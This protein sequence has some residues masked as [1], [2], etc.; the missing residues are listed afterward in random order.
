MRVSGIE[1]SLM[2]AFLELICLTPLFII[3]G[4]IVPPFPVKIHFIAFGFIF[5][6][7]LMLLALHPTKK[8]VLYLTLAIGLLQLC[9]PYPSIKNTIDI[10]F[11]PLV[12]FVLLDV[13]Y[14]QRLERSL[15]EKY[16]RR[17]L[18]YLWIPVVIGILQ[19]FGLMPITFWN[20]DYINWAYFEDGSKLPRPNGFLYHG[21]ELAIIIF[22]LTL[23]Q[24]FRKGSNAFWMLLIFIAIAKL[25]LYKALLGAIILLFFYHLFLM[26][27]TFSQM[28]LLSKKQLLGYS[29]VLL[30]VVSGISLSFLHGVYQQTGYYFPPQLLTGRGSIWNIYSDG[31]AD[32]SFW[33]YLFGSGM[34][35]GQELF[36]E[37]AS[38]DNYY[39]LRIDPVL[40]EAYDAHNAI[41]SLFVNTG[42]AGIAFFIWGF[43][44]IY[45]K[46]KGWKS[47]ID[48]GK[49]FFAL[50]IIPL[51]TIGITIP[52]FDMAIY[53][54]CLGFL[55][56]RWYFFSNE[57]EQVADA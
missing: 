9:L 12:L 14:N 44:Y 33:N 4:N 27:R 37:Y 32:Y 50:A 7:I 54:P 3:L 24:F 1:R 22:F 34:G 23:F 48:N 2:I 15:L 20:A 47:S 6:I 18:S 11:G 17:F 5:V 16:Q 38:P 35:S 40:H 45:L 13:L 29:L 41:L 55:I 46:A 31:I 30:V 56:Y 43:R 49:F 25:T 21:S 28:K 57:S 10:L 51:F 26:N 39:L 42:I 36:K 52:I 19:A 8:W 53:W